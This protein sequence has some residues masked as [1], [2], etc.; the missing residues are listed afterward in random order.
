MA[1]LLITRLSSG[2]AKVRSAD[3]FDSL[4][5]F[6]IERSHWKETPATA[7]VYLL[8]GQAP[9]GKLTVY[10]GMS[11]TNMRQRVGSHHVNKKKNWFGVLFSVPIKNSLLCPAIEAELIGQVTEAGVVDV[12]DNALSEKRKRDI[13][14]PQ[15]EPAVDKI[16]DALELIM[17]SDIFTP[18]EDEEKAEI[19]EP[20][21]RTPFLA[22]V[23]RDRAEEVRAR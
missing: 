9:D 20:I 15:I 22:R 7:G 17:G 13:D 5:I 2:V 14:D 10:V 1:D 6:R 11:T 23:Y 4:E 16:R 19:D 8:Y 12:I 18:S 21:A 3:P